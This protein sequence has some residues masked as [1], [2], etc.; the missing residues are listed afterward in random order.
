M[1]DDEREATNTVLALFLDA[2]VKVSA[3]EMALLEAGVLTQDRVRTFE[4]L[5]SRAEGF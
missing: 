1:T 3:L 4:L 2:I 5:L